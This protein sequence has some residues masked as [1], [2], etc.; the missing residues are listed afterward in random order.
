V[1]NKE[2]KIICLYRANCGGAAAGFK[3]L[4]KKPDIID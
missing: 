1:G 2:E 4:A 3:A